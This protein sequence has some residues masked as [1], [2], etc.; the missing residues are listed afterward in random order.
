M[1]NWNRTKLIMKRASIGINRTYCGRFYLCG[2]SFFSG[3]GNGKD[4]FN[5]KGAGK[6]DV[7]ENN[8]T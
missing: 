2:G 5:R 4:K 8:H 6:K 3:H 7:T 1:N